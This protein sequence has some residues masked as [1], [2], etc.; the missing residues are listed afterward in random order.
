MNKEYKNLLIA[1]SIP[2]TFTLQWQIG[3]LI[4]F[5]FPNITIFVNLDT[6][7]T[8]FLIFL[9]SIGVSFILKLNLKKSLLY[10]LLIGS[11]GEIV[12]IVLITFFAVLIQVLSGNLALDVFKIDIFYYYM[13]PR[14]LFQM[15]NGALGGV[16]GHLI[17]KIE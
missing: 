10:G 16:V 9:S 6:F 7:I 4:E 1:I 17:V 3:A 14:L 8:F 12:A 13:V 2:T 5:I 15:L 11:I